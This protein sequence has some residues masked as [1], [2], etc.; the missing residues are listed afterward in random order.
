VFFVFSEFIG[1][2]MDD[3]NRGKEEE[4]AMHKVGNRLGTHPMVEERIN[5]DEKSV[6][7]Q[8]NVDVVAPEVIAVALNVYLRIQFTT[9]RKFEQRNHMLS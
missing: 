9:D 2:V 3:S 5:V 1:V 6:N 8:P 4:N 7:E